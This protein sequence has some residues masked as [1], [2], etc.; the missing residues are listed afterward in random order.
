MIK[1]FNWI[2]INDDTFNL[3]KREGTPTSE[4]VLAVGDKGAI[5]VGRIYKHK[6]NRYGY[7]LTTYLGGGFDNVVKFVKCID[8][9]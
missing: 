5:L 4:E 2:Y 6:N 7:S 9:L 1:T 8:L 3:I